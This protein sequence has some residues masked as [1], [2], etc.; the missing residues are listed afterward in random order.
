MSSAAVVIGALRV[1]ISTELLK[2][3]VLS[4]GINGFAS[5]TSG[6]R[7]LEN[8]ECSDQHSHPRSMTGA[9]ALRHQLLLDL[10]YL[11]QIN[12]IPNHGA[13]MRKMIGIMTS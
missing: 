5:R 10:G 8:C 1:Y 4:S 7:S 12:K 9:F 13:R 2:P 6:L 11:Q 3:V